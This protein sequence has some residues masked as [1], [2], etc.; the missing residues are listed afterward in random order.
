MQINDKQML[1]LRQELAYLQQLDDKP[2]AAGLSL[3]LMER[4]L[5]EVSAP[6][7]PP[8]ITVYE[9][10]MVRLK[11]FAL[12]T[13]WGT[14]DNKGNYKPYNLEEQMD[15][16]TKLADWAMEDKGNAD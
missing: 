14:L 12:L 5:D 1:G 7:A 6:P 9:R 15:R 4:I 10:S 11:A 3:N 8:P 2:D 13:G 16:A